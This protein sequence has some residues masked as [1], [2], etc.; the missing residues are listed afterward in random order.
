MSK[1]ILYAYGGNNF[2]LVY[3]K[4]GDKEKKE[5]SSYNDDFHENEVKRCSLSRVK[6]EIKELAMCNDFEYFAT[7]TVNTNSKFTVNNRFN[8]EDCFERLRKLLKAYKRKYKNFGY[9]LIA[10]EHKKGGYHFHGLIK[11]VPSSDIINYNDIK[12]EQINQSILDAM[13]KGYK[14]YKHLFFQQL[15]W[16]VITPINNYFATCNY[17][18]KYISKAPCKTDKNTIYIRS[19]GLKFADSFYLPAEPIELIFKDSPNLINKIYKN[20]DKEK[21]FCHALDFNFD[22]IPKSAQ[23]ELF[24]LLNNYIKKT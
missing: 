20:D 18:T 3:L 2:R 21:D 24:Y 4:K 14:C 5:K 17:I 23:A 6:R 8:L 7:Y 11:G 1:L 22:N 9:L 12:N 13:N 15:G 16:N 10:E 19:R